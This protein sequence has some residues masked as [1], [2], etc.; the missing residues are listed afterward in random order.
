MS[1]TP[2]THQESSPL[3]F[4]IWLLGSPDFTA[5]L[6]QALQEPGVLGW[7]SQIFLSIVAYSLQEMLAELNELGKIFENDAVAKLFLGQTDVVI[8]Q[9][10][11]VAPLGPDRTSQEN[12]LLISL[13]RS[14]ADRVQPHALLL[15]VAEGARVSVEPLDAHEVV[16]EQGQN[17]TETVARIIEAVRRVLLGDS[18][19]SGQLGA[20]E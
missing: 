15:V 6:E 12:Q 5:A 8:A 9:A 14:L 4:N 11:G 20:E 17:G 16:V 1:T 7:E 18:G 19:E 2:A 13:Y 10:Y 3:A